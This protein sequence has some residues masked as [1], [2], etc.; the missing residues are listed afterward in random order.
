MGAVGSFS[1][2]GAH[3]ELEA[4]GTVL[5]HLPGNGNVC[6]RSCATE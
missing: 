4:S 2:P 5:G 6:A 3:S 1:L